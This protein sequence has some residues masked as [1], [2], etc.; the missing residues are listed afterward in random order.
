MNEITILLSKQRKLWVEGCKVNLSNPIP[1]KLIC[2]LA[3]AGFVLSD[4]FQGLISRDD[5]RRFIKTL[6]PYLKEAYGHGKRWKTVWLTP[7]NLPSSEESQK[8]IQVGLYMNPEYLKEIRESQKNV[9]DFWE[10][11]GWDPRTI[12]EPGYN[13]DLSEVSESLLSSPL[14]LGNDD[15]KILGWIMENRGDIVKVPSKIPVKET[16]SMALSFGYGEDCISGVTDILRVAS[17]LSMES[18]ILSRKTKICLSKK[19]R[20]VVLGLLERY[21][22]KKDLKYCLEDAKKYKELWK[23]LAKH[24][25]PSEKDYP[26]SY[27]F[28]GEILTG[29]KLMRRGWN[30]ILQEA[31]DNKDYSSVISLLLQRPSEFIRRYD[32]LLRKAWE[33]SDPDRMNLIQDSFMKIKGASPKVLFELY[34]YY[35]RRGE[36]FK[37][38]FLDNHGVRRMYSSLDPIPQELISIAQKSILETIKEGWKTKNTFEGKEVFIDLPEDIEFVLSMRNGV[39]DKTE[40]MYPGQK[41]TFPTTGMIRFFSQRIDPTGGEDLDLHA[42]LITDDGELKSISWNTSFSD[43]NKVICHSGDIRHQV[44]DCAEYVTIDYSK[45]LPPYTWMLVRVQNYDGERLCDVENWIGISEVSG[46][47]SDKGW[48]PTKSS[49]VF[50]GKVTSEVRDLSAFIVNIKEGWIRLILEGSGENL[51]TSD[52]DLLKQYLCRGTLGLKH[53]L[54]CYIECTGGEVVGTKTENSITI[55]PSDLMSGK[56]HELLLG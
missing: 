53:L 52:L 26:S 13:S 15:I 9:P 25:H 21:L 6:E 35:D 34:R 47:S 1:T 40:P 42:W 49:T 56:I 33:D 44:G 7:G 10:T 27:K 45:N 41:I 55:N 50:R 5:E 22:S 36:S 8:S 11:N 3:Q 39:S 28:F 24:C 31:Y 32:S 2:L 23:I 37:R 48:I 29:S 51:L 19:H 18:S 4:K 12:L 16:L 46:E 20:R 54:S 17:Y 43:Y 30:S 14:P 38:S